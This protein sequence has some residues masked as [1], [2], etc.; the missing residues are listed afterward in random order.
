M[1]QP[2][3]GSG[4]AAARAATA[5]AAK[6]PNGAERLLRAAVETG[7]WALSAGWRTRTALAG[8]LVIDEP[9]GLLERARAL[10][11]MRALI[12]QREFLGPCWD[13]A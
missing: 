3:A 2:R 9:E 10:A 7:P 8:G 6:P 13:S 1:T 5:P 11:P 4:N 12:A